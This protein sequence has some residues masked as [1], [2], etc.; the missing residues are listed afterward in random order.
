MTFYMLRLENLELHTCDLS[1]DG[2]CCINDDIK[3]DGKRHKVKDVCPLIEF[4]DPPKLRE[5]RSCHN[6]GCSGYDKEGQLNLCFK[7]GREIVEE[8]MLDKICAD[9]VREV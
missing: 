4:D 2:D 6:C 5:S 8:Q 1:E 7:Y 9:Y 3:C